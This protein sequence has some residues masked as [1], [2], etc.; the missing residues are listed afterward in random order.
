VTGTG[1]LPLA[2]RL[3]IAAV[4]AGGAALSLGWLTAVDTW[5]GNDLLA[6]LA[7]AAATA[8]AERFSLELS[9]RS[10]IDV[11]SL[12]DAIWIASMLLVRPS[13][14]ALAVGAG[15]LA[16]QALH[17]R[18]VLKIAFNAA[19]FTIAISAALA[20]FGALGAPPADEPRSWLAVALAMGLFQAVNTVVVAT[21]IAQTEGRPFRDVALPW[22]GV[23]QF[24]GN[25]ATGVLA[26]LV[27]TAQPLGLPLLLVPL[28]LS[29]L[30]YR[31]W[32]RALQERD[33]M[34][35]M[36]AT[37]D[38]IARSGDL[39]GRI[40]DSGGG[41]DSVGRLAATLN[42]M[43]EALE[44]SFQRER[45]FIRES[46]HELRTPITICRG[47]LE[48]LPAETDRDEQLETVAVI[49]DE[50][51]RMT[52]ILDDMSELA[53]MEDPASLRRSE[54]DLAR[55]LHDVALKTAALLN[56]RLVVEATDGR[57]V[58]ADGQRL[59]QA[60][61]NLLANAREHTP[62]DLPITVRVARDDGGWRIEVAD[63]GGGLAPLH[64]ERAFEPFYKSPGSD[65]SGLGLAIV[66]AIARA[67]GG[68]A[69][70][71]NSPGEGATFWIR[72]PQ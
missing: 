34:T 41:N 27:W 26:A 6:W 12:S 2:A 53:Y 44:S 23:L 47:H 51:D 60:L 18:P 17:R 3:L 40:A 9:Y 54:V 16:G 49:L 4:L 56:G 52:R 31:Q 67:H 39:A 14:L 70:V 35:H 37:A 13:V 71:D 11:Y 38:E 36:G 43:L 69:G 64:E 42:R 65:G 28:S 20:V 24:T 10:Q 63:R 45:T 55:L 32:L 25:L 58:E 61:I 68:E 1:R 46:S 5:T 72:I 7:I 57:T 50:L 62:P 48:L 8:A 29:Y 15:I 30:A 66:S 19:Q 22:I 59:Q 33:R 21:V